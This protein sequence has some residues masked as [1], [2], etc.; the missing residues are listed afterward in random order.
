MNRLTLMLVAVL[1][2]TAA[3]A[4]DDINPPPWRGQPNTTLQMWEFESDQNPTLPDVTINPNGDALAT[5]HGGLP[6]TFWKATDLLTTG[7]WRTEDYIQLDIPNFPEPRPE[8]LIRLQL[9]WYAIGQPEILVLPY[10]D[11]IVATEETALAT[12]YTHTTFHIHLDHNPP[13]ET[14]YILPRNCTVYVDEIVVDTWCV[15]E[16]ASLALLALAAPVALRRRR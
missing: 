12:G 13:N 7:V 5:V 6:F 16:P 3:A 10:A 15:P 9:T 14:I 8:K 4:A 1:S 2:M 11:D